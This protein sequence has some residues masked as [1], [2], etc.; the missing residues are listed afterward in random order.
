MNDRIGLILLAAGSSSRLGESKQ[1]LQYRGKTL[2]RHSV[3]VGVECGCSPIVV[4]VGHD[5]AKM[6]EE[7]KDAPAIV[8]ENADWQQ[9]MGTSIRV[10]VDRVE[11]EAPDLAA[12][13]LAVC[14]QP[15]V[16]SKVMRRLVNEYRTCGYPMAAATYAGTVGVP[17]VFN[18]HYFDKLKN[19]PPHAGAK[20]LLKAHGDQ[21]A[22]IEMEEAALDLDTPD[23]LR[24]LN[25]GDGA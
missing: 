8:A 14:D 1:L 4:V 5:A 22:K 17:A 16:D 13:V 24:H 6:R 10:G 21:V 18:R 23:D 2:L 12:V 25:G 9:G 20:Q 19:L 3:D 15:L 7:L 11:R